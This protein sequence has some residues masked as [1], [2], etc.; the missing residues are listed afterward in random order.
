MMHVKMYKP[1]SSRMKKTNGRSQGHLPG[2]GH[3]ATTPDV[4]PLALHP[5]QPLRRQDTTGPGHPASPARTSG[6]SQAPGNPAA[7]SD[8]RTPTNPRA[9]WLA[10]LALRKHPDIWPPLSAHSV[11]AEA[12]V[13]LRP[14]RLYILHLILF[15]RVS[16]GLA[17]I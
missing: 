16:I 7:S 4:R 9:T 2:P 8:I 14:H 1:A 6:P 12:R 10:S 13:P 17:H 15:S 3:P 11:R 5:P